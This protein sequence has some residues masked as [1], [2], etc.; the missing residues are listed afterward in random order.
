M[1]KL[2]FCGRL[3]AAIGDIFAARLIPSPP[4]LRE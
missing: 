1:Q 2:N 3:R 4:P